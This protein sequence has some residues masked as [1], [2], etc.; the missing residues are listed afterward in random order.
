MMNNEGVQ[1]GRCRNG[2]YHL[3]SLVLQCWITLKFIFP[4]SCI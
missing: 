2:M 3:G 1:D 4:S